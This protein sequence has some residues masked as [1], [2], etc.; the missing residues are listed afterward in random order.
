MQAVNHMIARETAKNA[1]TQFSLNIKEP[2]CQLDVLNRAPMEDARCAIETEDSTLPEKV[3]AQSKIAWYLLTKN[4]WYV[5]LA[6]PKSMVFVSSTNLR[7][8]V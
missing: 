1:R 7:K 5:R 8:F 2:A 3:T 4:V 6:M